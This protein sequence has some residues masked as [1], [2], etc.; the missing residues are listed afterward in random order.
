MV[1]KLVHLTLLLA[2]A[3]LVFALPVSAAAPNFGPA[4]YADGQAWGTKALGSLPPPNDHNGQSFD[5]LFAFTNGVAGQLPVSEAGP[6]NPNY[7]GGRWSLQS[8]T[9][10]GG[11]QPVLITSYA[12]LAMYVDAG[13]IT[14]TSANTYFLCPLLPVK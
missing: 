3:M 11:A 2:L 4:I 14:V 6:G 10:A 13:L 5:M 9:W 12:Q 1:R 7:N 8:A